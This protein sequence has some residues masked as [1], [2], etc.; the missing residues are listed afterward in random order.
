MGPRSAALKL[1]DAYIAIGGD[2]SGFTTTLEGAE[3]EAKAAGERV[4][5][6]FSPRRVIGA[7]ATAAAA[8]FAVMTKGAADLNAAL[9]ET[10]ARSGAV[11]AQW[12]AMAAAIARQ[13]RRTTLSLAE[14]SEGITA[15]KTDL[16]ASAEEVGATAD[17]LAD[18]AL[19]AGESFGNVVRGADDLADAFEVSLAETLA[20]HDALIA[21]QQQ[22]GGVITANREALIAMA[23]GL[24]GANLEWQHGL[25]LI[26]LF[27]SA[28]VDAAA[29]PLA[30]QRAL[31]Q[32]E[33]PEELHRLIRDISET[34]DNFER[35][36]KAAEL[37][38]NRAGA[39]MAL[40]LAPGR[41]ALD[42]YMIGVDESAGTTERAARR[43]DSSWRRTIELLMRNVAGFAAEVGNAM[44]PVLLI[45]GQ[46]GSAF[47]GLAMMFPGLGPRMAAG[48]KALFAGLIPTAAAGGSTVGAVA[49]AAFMT[50]FKLAAI[51]IPVTVIL[52]ARG[53]VA[54]FLGL[55]RTETPGEAWDPRRQMGLPKAGPTVVAAAPPSPEE[56]ALGEQHRAYLARTTGPGR[57]G[58]A[59]W[60]AAGMPAGEGFADGVAEGLA[61]GADQVTAAAELAFGGIPEAAAGLTE[62][63][64]AAIAANLT[65]AANEI[66]GQQDTIS[67]L[68]AR[69]NENLERP[70]L[71]ATVEL[72]RL[73]RAR[74]SEALAAELRSPDRARRADAAA[75]AAQLDAA[76]EALRPRPGIMSQ[77]STDLI[78]DLQ[79]ST[80]VDLRRF[81]A[82]FGETLEA[83]TTREAERRAARAAWARELMG[84]PDGVR[85]GIA[86]ARAKTAAAAALEELIEAALRAA[87]PRIRADAQASGSDFA[88]ALTDAMGNVRSQTD[89]VNS[90]RDVVAAAVD[91]L[92]SARAKSLVADAWADLT[93]GLRLRLPG[94]AGPTRIYEPEIPG[95]ATGIPYVPRDQL[96]YIHA[97]EAVL[98]VPQAEN[99]R[100]A[101]MAGAREQHINIER[102]ELVDAHDE[103]SLIARLRFLAGVA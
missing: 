77:V 51:A 34:E 52:A 95:A 69:I 65:A 49:G 43:I 30:L 5:R 67:S 2:A 59:D 64:R 19:V 62:A 50:A 33:S 79:T 58:F 103:L 53:P 72:E 93:A 13:N 18:F 57:L 92:R 39:K 61:A 60:K 29:I 4:E 24:R 17:A 99:W 76:I 81:A 100:A 68:I 71:T 54:D 83:E 44:G 82:W 96:T 86:D 32:V 97:R 11:G 6:S 63:T 80:S 9:A 36:Q 10:Q 91:Y 41:G 22:F 45:L 98:T 14:I 27:N 73:L 74:A 102:V 90:M 94:A 8:G 101:A 23:P 20:I 1:L 78:A 12:E 21:G 25:A 85:T 70:P 87:E 38:G 37:F 3:R 42:D 16:R 88:E 84:A 15:I 48:L 47:T 55:S 66:R 28:G 56:A 40:A 75:L 46:V 89:A 26:N 7:L 31:M 35:A